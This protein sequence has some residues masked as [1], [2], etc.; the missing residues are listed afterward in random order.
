MLPPRRASASHTSCFIR[1]GPMRLIT[2][3]SG[4]ET[5]YSVFMT[6]LPCSLRLAYSHRLQVDGARA[7]GDHG[8]MKPGLRDRLRLAAHRPALRGIAQQLAQP[9]RDIARVFGIDE[10][11]G[12][13]VTDHVRHPA[14][15]RGDD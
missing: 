12:L 6:G 2:A 3:R 8:R 7:C 1:C 15:V 4:L 9:V 14:P 11:A 10:E 5:L 13:A